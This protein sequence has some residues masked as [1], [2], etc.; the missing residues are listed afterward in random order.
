MLEIIPESDI[1]E[2]AFFRNTQEVNAAV[3][4]IYSGLRAPI[5]LEWRMTELRSDN[6]WVGEKGSATQQ[7]RDLDALDMFHPP[8]MMPE[9][10]EY[11]YRT[12]QYISACNNVLRQLDVVTDA[13]TRA[14]FEGEARFIRALGHF[15]LVRLFGPIFLMDDLKTPAQAKQ[16]NRV[17]VNIIYDFIIAD[18]DSAIKKLPSSYPAADMGRATS[19]AAK[20]LL[21]KVYMTLN[22]FESAR[23]LIEDVVNSSGHSLVTTSTPETET[24]PFVPAYANVFLQDNNE[25]IFAVRFNGEGGVGSNFSNFF[26]PLNSLQRVVNA[27]VSRGLNV[28][29]WDLYD[30][31]AE[32]DTIRKNASIGLWR[33]LNDDENDRVRQRLY[34]KKFITRVVMENQS[35]QN[36]PILRFADAMLMLA[37]CINELEGPTAE[38]FRLINLVRRRGGQGIAA[39]HDVR[40]D[41]RLETRLIIENERRWELTFE[42]HRWFDLVRTDRAIEVIMKQIFETDYEYYLRYEARTP[43][44]GEIIR[45]WQLLL[46]IPEREIIANNDIIITQNFGY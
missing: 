31:Y 33:G 20:M 21:A 15:N 29:T 19:W 45:L 35:S 24:T 25:I 11:W 17:P 7:N 1:T 34:P 5:Q 6:T 46:P 9:I 43:V 38:V 40:S 14:Q 18:L 23:E 28:P 13:R 39:E 22:D 42:N 3:I 2:T 8:V 16:M 44:S 37:E 26:A 32:Y 10:Y 41:S 36:F 30:S 27:G 12:Y 4:G